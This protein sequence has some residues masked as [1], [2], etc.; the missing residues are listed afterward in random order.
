M[1]LFFSLTISYLV[2]L[3]LVCIK[4]G[5]SECPSRFSFNYHSCIITQTNTVKCFGKNLFGQLGLGHTTYIGDNANEMGEYLSALN[6][7]EKVISMHSGGEHT[8]VHLVTLEAQCWGFNSYGQ[9][10]EG[11][12]SNRGDAS[13]EMGVYLP[14]INVGVGIEDIRSGYHYNIIL[15]VGGIVKMWGDNTYGT[16]GYGDNS[17]RG[18]SPGEMGN[19]LPYVDLG[20]AVGEVEQMY[21][22]SITTCVKFDS[23]SMKCWGYNPNGQCGLEHSSN[24]GDSSLEMGD[25]L[26]NV[27]LPSGTTIDRVIGGLHHFGILSTTGDVYL[28]GYQ[29]YGA[30]GIGT[31]SSLGATVGDMGDNLQSA[32]MGP[33]VVMDLLGGW[34]HTCAILDNFGLKCWGQGSSGQTG[35]GDTQARGDSSG[36]MG[37][38]LPF[39]NLG[40]GGTATAQSLHLGRDFTCV[41]LGDDSLKCFGVNTSGQLGQGHTSSI[42]NSANQ[43]GDYLDPVSL[44]AG[45]EVLLCGIGETVSPSFT[46]DPTFTPTFSP[47]FAPTTPS[48]TMDPTHT[49]TFTPTTPAPTMD[50]TYTPTFDPSFSFDPTFTPTQQPTFTPTVTYQ[51]TYSPTLFRS[52]SSK[53]TRGYH[54]CIQTTSQKIKCFGYNGDGQLGLQ[55]T[56]SRGDSSFE[57]GDYL[58]FV[59][60]SENSISVTVGGYHSCALLTTRGVKCW[61]DGAFGQ[62]GTGSTYNIGDSSGEMGSK[63]DEIELGSGVL[64][65]DLAGGYYHNMIITYEGNIKA[66]GYGGYGR[67]GYEHSSSIGDNTGELGDY[68]PYIDVGSGKVVSKL[69]LGT[70]HSCALLS[71]LEM[72]C[73]GYNLYGYLGQEHTSTIGWAYHDMGDYLPPISFPNGVVSSNIRAS[74]THTSMISSVGQLFMFGYNAYGQL[75]IGH[76]ISIG[77]SINEMGQY[78]QPTNLGSGRSVKEVDGGFYSTCALLDDFSMKCWGYNIYGQLGYGDTLQRGDSTVEMGDYL[79]T[80]DLGSGRTAQNIHVGGYH[81]CV[82]LDN[83]D[84]KCFGCSFL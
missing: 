24:V 17:N 70:D 38:F 62:V 72:K 14:N 71:S 3:A 37:S 43:M 40:S 32:D 23:G 13:G 2:I 73:W 52:C 84:L 21:T 8:C 59:D 25:N 26:P 19:Y 81:T 67:L 36:E 42:G 58:P 77:D 75:G 55:D 47:S 44:G 51:P 56:S 29:P 60:L 15:T 63:L 53:I 45:V 18:D 79:P 22:G 66:W 1:R 7:L 12:T 27:N 74:N 82:E 11:S 31:T 39:V 10:G 50:P 33:E 9:L 61:G 65:A 5:K 28:W 34:Y 20:G 69:S 57:M 30:L 80:I 6:V 76:T 4:L 35:Y 64:I 46:F 49:P 48:P 83:G 78:L 41:Q 16:L 68:L 54:S